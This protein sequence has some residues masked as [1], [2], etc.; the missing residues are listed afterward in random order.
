MAKQPKY[1]LPQI[2]DLL[3]LIPSKDE[4]YFSPP[5]ICVGLVIA[6]IKWVQQKWWCIRS[7]SWHQKAY[8]AS[9]SISRHYPDTMTAA[10]WRMRDHVE[11][12]LAIAFEAVQDQEAPNRPNNWPEIQH[13]W[14]PLRPET[15][16]ISTCP[17]CWLMEKWVTL[18]VAVLKH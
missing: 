10:C 9:A 14:A 2:H 13:E 8:C 16:S 7:E 18:I 5:W 1:Y 17:N 6:L 4:V 15:Q 3:K 12:R 11:Q